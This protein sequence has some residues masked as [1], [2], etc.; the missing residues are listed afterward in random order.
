MFPV[1]QVCL[2]S[3]CGL[4]H[5]IGMETALMS[6][7]LSGQRGVAELLCLRGA[8]VAVQNEVR[9]LSWALG[10]LWCRAAA[11]HVMRTRSACL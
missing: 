1:A 4:G 11:A 9:V 6:A 2:M 8:V 10:W 3:R 7:A 5:G